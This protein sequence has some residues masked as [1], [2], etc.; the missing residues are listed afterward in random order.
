MVRNWLKAI[1]RMER[2][3][4]Y[5]WSGVGFASGVYPVRLAAVKFQDKQLFLVHFETYSKCC[6][7]IAIRFDG[8]H[9]AQFQ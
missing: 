5:S 3:V 4:S 1:K 2:G 9:Q 8:K 6:T 7:G